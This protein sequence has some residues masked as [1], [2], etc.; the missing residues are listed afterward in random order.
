MKFPSLIVLILFSSFKLHSQV[1]QWASAIGNDSISRSYSIAHDNSGNCIITGD[2]KGSMDFNPGAGVNN[3][4]ALGNTDLFVA[5]YDA[6]GNY[7]WAFDLGNVGSFAA[8]RAVTTEANGNI[9][10]T[11][12]FAGAIDFD[13]G[14]GANILTS[15][16]GF[17][18]D[19][20]VA[21]YDASGNFVW[22]FNIGGVNFSVSFPS[23]VVDNASDILVTGSLYGT[24]DFDPGAGVSNL[25]SGI[26]VQDAIVAK[27]S[28]SG[29]YMWAFS[30]G[31][32]PIQT[33]GV[34]ITTDLNTDVIVTGFLGGTADF[35]PGVGTYNLSSQ[36]NNS[37]DVFLAK[38]SNSGNFLWAFNI[39]DFNTGSQGRSVV[40]DAIGNIYMTG[41]L[42][43]TNVDFDPGVN[44]NS[45]TSLGT[46]DIFLSKYDG[47]GN[48]LWAFNIGSAAG[49]YFVSYSVSTDA[50]SNAYVCGS[51]AG[52]ADFNPS[53]GINNLI[54]NINNQCAFVVKYDSNGNYVWAF[55]INA[56]GLGGAAVWAGT[57]DSNGSIW[58]VGG[59]FFGGINYDFDPG[60]AITYLNTI[61]FGD[62]VFFA[63]Y[64]TITGIQENVFDNAIAVFPNPGDG[65]FTLSY[66]GEENSNSVSRII[67]KNSLGKIVFE[68]GQ[69][70]AE[71]N[72]ID[73]SA[74][75]NGIYFLDLYIGNQNCLQKI[76]I[77]K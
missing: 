4:N 30:F 18:G 37:S 7:L 26:G 35:D 34:S 3:L 29:N 32:G 63:K 40:T 73:L 54:G 50:N 17:T 21:K 71:Q 44:T 77:A 53:V 24:I 45:L 39:G 31:G 1:L 5:K 28:S 52:T 33:S 46:T 57:T 19:V 13:P 8:G 64:S 27:Y 65:H 10:L 49:Y 43:G 74:L 61:G 58:V 14:I 70:L 6:G 67:V 60:F 62:D 20:F 16:G 47:N 22:A 42:S 41:D 48:Y 75:A 11:G 72:S 59:L 68:K 76:I 2:F 15:N 12:V 55:Q 25:A 56:S 66:S 36:G 38:Y 69:I 51:F 9:I 23:I